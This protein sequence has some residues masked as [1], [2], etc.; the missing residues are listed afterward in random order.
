MPDNDLVS[1]YTAI[2]KVNGFKM[3]ILQDTGTTVD[4]V[5]R[6]RI[7]PE[8]LTE[9]ELIP[10]YEIPVSANILNVSAQNEPNIEYSE[11]EIANESQWSSVNGEN[12]ESQIEMRIEHEDMA[13]LMQFQKEGIYS[14][15]ETVSHFLVSDVEEDTM[16][17]SL[18][19][20]TA[21]SL[22]TENI[23]RD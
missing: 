16:R 19:S 20:Q 13:E 23:E 21:E 4:I 5:F 2:E 8:M 6:N 15:V 18:N 3:P 1:P 14:Q 7:R 12:N 9:E 17:K 11:T 10:E 22:V